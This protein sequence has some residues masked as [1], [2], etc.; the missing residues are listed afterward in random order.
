VPWPESCRAQLNASGGVKKLIVPTV[1]MF[2]CRSVA[3]SQTFAAALFNA[4]VASPESGSE[5]S[6]AADATGATRIQTVHIKPFI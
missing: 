3:L 6:I 2:K 5:T 1:A 4:G